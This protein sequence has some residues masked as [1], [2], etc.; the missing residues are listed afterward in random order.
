LRGESIERLRRALLN[1]TIILAVGG[2]GRAFGMQ[3]LSA[4]LD[5]TFVPALNWIPETMVVAD[6]VEAGSEIV[7]F[8]LQNDEP[9]LVLYLGP[10]SILAL[11][12][13]QRVERWGQAPPEIIL[14][15]GWGKG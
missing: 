2:A 10:S 4:V 12:P 7:R 9:R 1:G 8:W 15:S 14:G 5:E 13:G 3:V 6:A 11:G